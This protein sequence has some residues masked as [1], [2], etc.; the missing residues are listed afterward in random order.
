[1]ID[2]NTHNPWKGLNYYVEGEVI[3]GRNSE[4]ESLSQYI[5]N[6]PQTVL[7][8]KSGIGKSSILNAGIFPIARRNGLYPVG[9]RLDHSNTISYLSQIKE[10]I[11]RAGAKAKELLPVIN[12]ETETLW[13]YLHRNSFTDAAGNPIELL[14]VF[15]QFEEIFTLQQNE[16]VKKDFFS[17]LADLINRITPSYIIE[18]ST[19]PEKEKDEHQ[20]LTLDNLE[21][22]EFEE[23][24]DITTDYLQV[25]AFHIVI[26]LRED[27]L[28]YLE[29]YT[30]YIPGMKS[31]RYALLPINE[32]QAAD[33]IMRPQ[34][35]LVSTDVAELI[36]QKVTGKND[37]ALDGI[38]EIDVDAAVL[39]LY[40]SRLFI[41]KG[42]ADSISAELVNQFSEDIIK[43]FYEESVADLP[44]KDVEKIEDEL[45]TYD[46]RRNNVSRNDLIREGIPEQIIKTLVEDR[47]LLRQFSYQDDIR[48]EFMHDILCPIVNAR[49]DQ[50]E[51]ARQQ[52]EE[53]QRQ[54][55]ERKKQEEEKKRILFEEKQKR[56]K[57]ERE[58]EEEKAR[59]KAEAIRTKKRNR[60]R[61]YAIGSIL[62]FLLLGSVL[63]W[64][65]NKK[66][67]KVSYASF[68]TKD[69][70]PI[71][72][73]E[74]LD[75]N[76]KKQMP[77]YY[78]LIKYGYRS[79]YTRVNV[80]N[81]HK[82]IT[83]NIFNESPLVGLYETE[84][85]D[86]KAKSFAILQRQTAYWLFTPDNDGNI[87]R[88]TA[89]D[90][91]G[92]ELY[93]VQYFRSSA[94]SAEGDVESSQKKQLWAN[95]VDKDGK[96][97][98]IRDNGADRVRIINDSLGYIIGYQ[99]YS[100]T[101]T[102]QPNL[103][104]YYGYRYQVNDSGKIVRKIP[105][106]AFGDTISNKAITY[107][108]F[109]K[110]CRWTNSTRGKAEYLN[111]LVVFTM[112][113]RIDSLKI[114]SQ[115]ELIY[116]SETII[117]GSSRVF[118]YEKGQVIK[119]F[120]Y[121]LLD[122][123]KELVY[124]KQILPSKKTNIQET[125]VYWADSTVHYRLKKE[126]K[127]KGR[128]TIAYYG[129]DYSNSIGS[130]LMVF[131]PEGQYHKL[132]IDTTYENGLIKVEKEYFDTNDKPSPIC[133]YNR[134][135]TYFNKDN[136][137]LKHIVY[138]NGE[139][140]YSY[141]NEYEDGQI[142]AQLVLGI[143]DST[144]VRFA[145]WDKYHLCYYKMK[146]VYN[147]SNTLV[148]IK[149]INE[150]GEE[151]LIT[152]PGNEDY[153]ISIVPSKEMSST[154]DGDDIYG[155]Q[156]YK[157]QTPSINKDRRVE[158]IHILN[159]AGT[160]YKAGIRDGDLLV[161]NGNPIK[162]ARS[163]QA[164]NSYDLFTFPIPDGLSGAEHYPVYFTEKEMKRYNNALIM[165]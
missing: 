153:N 156:V 100:E 90:S 127:G 165:K 7:Y 30:A 77:V 123:G 39:S 37:F 11:R 132:V 107:L 118:H 109:D 130:P 117:N 82:K 14:L 12:E 150:F 47:K 70:W 31:N 116:H 33:I 22:I 102:P 59:L 126:E 28:S 125:Q 36:I 104:D 148:A 99:F 112:D 49:I 51:L 94:L 136:E 65:W 6:N 128:M 43:D 152:T 64:L 143:D 16:K 84:G 40:L 95:Y 163:N 2:K 158:Y 114:D 17:Q 48:V 21:D 98:R 29:R 18:A 138:K 80:L 103:N 139:R 124:S 133:K 97:M 89:Y 111:Q 85:I 154:I 86:A 161:S 93:A 20:Q 35:G 108:T 164:K 131:M 129:G 159:M 10:A 76:D 96:S 24:D 53:R 44:V 13:E 32:E 151:S 78:Q 19:K 74:P 57:I 55:E 68:T 26:T 106:D 58:A 60:R 155:L 121:R 3:Y 71:G 91:D 61:L 69:G 1:M 56:E 140:I 134:D 88:K 149:G 8:G 122:S 5:I 25:D 41:K 160:W 162:I 38:P 45:L 52:E 135:V 144:A 79:K 146:L 120:Y 137:M 9:I 15:D 83:H 101:G 113:S 81:S 62:F 72:I 110:Y 63:Y 4:I 42:N 50:R 23:D 87:L 66:E 46:G 119:T 147:F 34:E 141:L 157:V 27:F 67:Y 142:T 73:G 115:G 92:N 145:G 105:V 75:D 54:E